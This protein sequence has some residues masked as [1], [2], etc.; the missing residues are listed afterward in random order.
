MTSL[1]V[2]Y[3]SYWFNPS[4][5]DEETKKEIIELFRIAG[6]IA[7][8]KTDS[9]RREF[10]ITASKG[11]IEEFRQRYRQRYDEDASEEELQRAFGE[12]DQ[13][14]YWYKLTLVHFYDTWQEEE[15][16]GIFLNNRYLLAINDRNANGYPVDARDLIRWMQQETHKVI[17]E[18][19]ENTYNERVSRELP[20]KLRYG[21]ISRKNYWD[22]YPEHR[23][24]FREA[25][26]L[27]EA[28]RFLAYKQM[29]RKESIDEHEPENCREELTAR[30]FFEACSCGYKA[31]NLR[32]R[33]CWRFKDSE[34]EHARYGGATPKEMYYMFADGRDEGL[35]QVPMDD[36]DEFAMWIDGKG[37]YRDLHG[38]HPYEILPSMDPQN[39]LHLY[40]SKCEKGYY[41][42]LTG[43]TLFRC[44][45]TMIFYNALKDNGYP[46]TLEGM[47]I[48]AARLEETDDIG[49]VPDFACTLYRDKH[50]PKAV[51]DLEHLSD[52]DHAEQ[53]IAK[54]R[55]LEIEKVFLNEDKT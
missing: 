21:M 12:Y 29:L 48:I 32:L 31:L 26:P 28:E 22:I 8:L 15:F 44:S 3:Y 43:A 11:T 47:D 6:Q 40:V 10:W 24:F 20:Y 14:E 23:K 9:E 27:S 41:F 5:A 42:S 55:W 1:E 39:S 37:K 38:G 7:P 19:Q 18:L 46:V 54:T 16:Y 34:K 49:L 30:D 35:M 17:H 50:F 52:G 51:A 25:V 45:D 2:D 33:R 36:P 13:D 53:V 4:A